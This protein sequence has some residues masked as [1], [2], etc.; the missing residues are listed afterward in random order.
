MKKSSAAAVNNYIRSKRMDNVSDSTW[1]KSAC[2]QLL[3]ADK[4]N[5]PLSFVQ[6]IGIAIYRRWVAGGK[7]IPLKEII[8][9]SNQLLCVGVNGFVGKNMPLQPK[10]SR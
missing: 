2:L 1:G 7:K 6:D 9:M 5:I 4:Q 3:D 8:E 10:L